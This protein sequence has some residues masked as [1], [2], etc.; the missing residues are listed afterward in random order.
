MAENFLN[1]IRQQFKKLDYSKGKVKD[2]QLRLTLCDL[3][4][5]WNSPGQ[6]A[7]AGKPFPSLGIFP[8]QGSNP[9]LPHC[10]RILYQLSY[11]GSQ[12]LSNKNLNTFMSRH[13]ILKLLET[14]KQKNLEHS[15]RKMIA[16]LKVK[17][18]TSASTFLVRN[19]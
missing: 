9:G 18:N 17:N 5:P 8:T 7:G 14:N 16:Y 15:Q 4:S 10:R 19:H 1:L 2:A 12:I 13:I 6:K 3:Y 11:Q